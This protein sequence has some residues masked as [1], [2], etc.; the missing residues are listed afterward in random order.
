MSEEKAYLNDVPEDYDGP[1]CEYANKHYPNTGKRCGLP[2]WLGATEPEPHCEFHSEAKPD[3]LKER[4]EDAVAHKASLQEANLS[5]A[6]LNDAKLS[7]ASLG[8]ANL[9]GAKLVRANLSGAVLWNA[10]LLGADLD[11]ACLSEAYLYRA[12][13]SG[14][15]LRRALLRKVNLDQANLSGANLF[16]A[17]LLGANLRGAHFLRLTSI[18]N[19]GGRFYGSE[20]ISDLRKAN[21]NGVRFLEIEIDPA[22]N[23]SHAVFGPE[24]G[25]DEDKILDEI[26][27]TAHEEWSSC[28]AVYCQLKLAFQQQGDYERAGNFFYRERYC[29][30]RALVKEGGHKEKRFW[31]CLFEWVAGYGE[32]P[33]L[34]LG[35]AAA[36]IL[37]FGLLQAIFGLTLSDKVPPNWF[38]PLYHSC[39]TFAT[40]GYGDA[41]PSGWPGQVAAASEAGLGIILT[42]LFMICLVRKFSR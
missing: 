5:G 28:A 31:E 20:Q 42:S 19:R 24:D 33:L 9:S 17:I 39:I 22:T 1:R 14:A 29:Q 13:L 37:F 38:T 26:G 15:N 12:E 21:L 16:N 23:L 4:L 7:G 6:K 18:S 25:S 10:N 35:W 41:I 3:D 32:Q 30:R 8:F 34:V 40:V 11:Q 2:A 27:A 36:L